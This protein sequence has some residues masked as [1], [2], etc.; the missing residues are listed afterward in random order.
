MQFNY[1][2]NI[3]VIKGKG[4]HLIKMIEFNQKKIKF[5]QN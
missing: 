2:N 5:N 3:S 4:S 1:C